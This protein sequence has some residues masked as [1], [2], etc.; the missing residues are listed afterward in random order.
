MDLES[1]SYTVAHDLRGPLRAMNGFAT[2]LEEDYG[3]RLDE[4]GHE[5]TR[6]I[7]RSAERMDRLICDVLDYS[8]ITRA[9]FESEP[10]PLEPLLQGIIESYPA[11]QNPET[12]NT[13]EKL[14]RSMITS[15]SRSVRARTNSSSSCA[16]DCSNSSAFF[17]SV[18]STVTPSVRT[19]R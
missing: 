10:V 14:S 3:P 16:C 13:L 17:R 12:A 5:Y 9:T 2:A 4:Q 19:G 11:L 8:K 1:F 15:C 6:R 7:T 18:I